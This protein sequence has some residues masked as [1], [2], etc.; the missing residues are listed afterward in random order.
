MTGAKRRGKG[1]EKSHP[2]GGGD[3]AGFRFARERNVVLVAGG[4]YRPYTA[5]MEPQVFYTAL[6]PSYYVVDAEGYTF[7]VAYPGYLSATGN[8]CVGAP[9]GADGNPLTDALIIW[10]RAGGSYEY[11]LLLYDGENGYQIMADSRGHALDSALEPV[12]QAHAPSVTALFRKA[13]AWWAL[14]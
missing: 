1:Y 6:D 7:S 13:N 14:A 8:L 5:G 10:P 2:A 11:G 9:M 4:K 3:A 12:V